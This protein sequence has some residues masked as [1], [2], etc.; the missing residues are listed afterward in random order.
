[1]TFPPVAACRPNEKLSPGE[2]AIIE[3]SVSLLARP[4]PP[5]RL[6]ALGISHCIFS[7]CGGFVWACRPLSSPFRRCS[8]R[9]VVAERFGGL[10][11][12]VL[13]HSLG[14]GPAAALAHRGG[15]RRGATDV[16]VGL[17]PVV[18]LEK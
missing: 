12:L 16:V 1:M 15:G 3:D 13:S 14:T 11:P 17:Y 7:L 8:T 2:A 4:G 10:R 18:D 5:G 9:A 6:G